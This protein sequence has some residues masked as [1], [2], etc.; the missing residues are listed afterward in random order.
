MKT[1]KKGFVFDTENATLVVEHSTK[2]FGSAKIYRT[3][4]GRYF[5]HHPAFEDDAETIDYLEN[6]VDDIDTY[7]AE[8]NYEFEEQAVIHFEEF[9]EG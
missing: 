1:L 4:N 9:Q 8:W 3:E 5:I 2:E 6:G 7:I